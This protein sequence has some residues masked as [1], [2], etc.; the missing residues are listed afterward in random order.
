MEIRKRSD[1]IYAKGKDS[2]SRGLEICEHVKRNGKK[3]GQVCMRFFIENGSQEQIRFLMEPREAFSLWMKI[4]KVIRSTVSLKEP[5]TV[6]KIEREEKGVKTEIFTTVTVE[7]YVKEGRSGY[8]ITCVRSINNV[9][10]S[11][12]IPMAESDFMFCGELL[13]FLSCVQAWETYE[14]NDAGR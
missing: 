9:K 12:N 3:H 11:Y 7:K 10:N 8:A 2:V 13:K 1:T 5:S 6:H 4:T 14:R